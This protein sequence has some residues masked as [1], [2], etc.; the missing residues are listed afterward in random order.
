[1]ASK[2]ETKTDVQTF[3]DAEASDSLKRAFAT[4]LSLKKARP[5]LPSE[6]SLTPAI[7]TGRFDPAAIMAEVQADL[8][9]WAEKMGALLVTLEKIGESNPSA[10]I[11]LVNRTGRT[12]HVNGTRLLSAL[13]REDAAILGSKLAA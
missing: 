13:L 3:T 8:E 5:K 12:T 11:R 9:T 6:A 2:T 1:M 7:H 4:Y 10:N